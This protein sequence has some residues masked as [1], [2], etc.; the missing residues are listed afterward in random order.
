[1]TVTLPITVTHWSPPEV[2]GGGWLAAARECVMGS[3][4]RACSSRSWCA[5]CTVGRRV[6][7][8]SR[9]T[10]TMGGTAGGW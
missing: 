3:S 1:M 8:T 7:D 5:Q 4:S 6:A 10:I 2:R 9:T